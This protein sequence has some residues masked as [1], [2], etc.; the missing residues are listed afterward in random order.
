MMMMTFRDPFTV[1][2]GHRTKLFRG[3]TI[4]SSQQF[5][6]VY[7]VILAGK[8]SQFIEVNECPHSR[9]GSRGL[10]SATSLGQGQL[11][12]LLEAEAKGVHKWPPS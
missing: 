9:G 8:M 3:I 6:K 2:P 10:R 5:F 12:T 4:D 11:A 7:G 1:F